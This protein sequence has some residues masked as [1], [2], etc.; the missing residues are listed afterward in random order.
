[1][2]RQGETYE[3][4][5]GASSSGSPRLGSRPAQIIPDNLFY[6]E[7][8]RFVPLQ[9]YA[10]ARAFG[11]I[12]GRIENNIV[13][14]IY[15]RD[16][17]MVVVDEDDLSVHVIDKEHADNLGI[18][19]PLPYKPLSKPPLHPGPQRRNRHGFN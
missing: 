18:N 2:R 9:A 11:C 15:N 6:I 17:K 12:Y 4:A 16:H 14:P 13:R 1:M 5:G 19:K 7:N 10:L 3:P 8:D